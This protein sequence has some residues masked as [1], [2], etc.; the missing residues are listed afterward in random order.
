MSIGCLDDRGYD[1]CFHG[2]ML[3]MVGSEGATIG[4]ILK[5][6]QNLYVVTHQSPNSASLLSP[7]LNPSQK[8]K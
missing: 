5:T 2:S 3:E 7:F 6:I 4:V 1:C 8:S